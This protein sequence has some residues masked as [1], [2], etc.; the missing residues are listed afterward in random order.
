MYNSAHSRERHRP[1]AAVVLAV[2]VTC[3]VSG[4]G[5]AEFVLGERILSLGSW[6]ADVFHLQRELARI[7]YQIRSDGHFGKE[8]ERAVIAFQISNGLEPDGVVGERT[9]AALSAVRPF[10]IYTVRDGD[11]LEA[12]AEAFDASIVELV[13]LNNLPGGS[14]QVG[15]VLQ[16]PVRPT[17]TVRR[18]DTLSAIAIRYGTTIQALV[19]LNDIQDPNLIQVGTVLRLPRGAEPTIPGL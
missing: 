12:L 6:G 9:L 5:H 15:D 19:E 11:T 2:V 17:Y 4:V 13:H 3:M 7:G 16:V 14:I 8:T 10:I 18:G 1:V